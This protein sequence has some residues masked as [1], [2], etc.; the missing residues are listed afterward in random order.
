MAQVFAFTTADGGTVRL[1]MNNRLGVTPSTGCGL[2]L[3]MGMEIG[4]ADIEREILTQTPYDGGTVA[5]A[6]RPLVE[7]TFGLMLG[8][9]T[10]LDENG[11]ETGTGDNTFRTSEEMITA[12]EALHT[13]LSRPRNT[14]KYQPDGT[15]DYYLIDTYEST[16]P[17]IRSGWVFNPFLMKGAVFQV[18]VLRHPTMRGSAASI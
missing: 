7:M 4:N 5:S 15:D 2:M 11:I 9:F 18:T 16:L 17:S 13:E 12:V 8:R 3:L 6:F 1:D 10:E 14:I